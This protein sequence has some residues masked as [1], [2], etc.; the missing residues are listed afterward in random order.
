MKVIA[1]K[2]KEI[3]A[4]IVARDKPKKVNSTFLQLT[5]SFCNSLRIFYL[6]KLFIPSLDIQTKDSSKKPCSIPT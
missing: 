4:F 5:T 2:T 1:L 6:F 3:T